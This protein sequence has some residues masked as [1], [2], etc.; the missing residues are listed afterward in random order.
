MG[1]QGRI[2]V[3]I[4]ATLQGTGG[5]TVEKEDGTWT[6]SPDF[7]GLTEIL[8][9]S[10]SDPSSK[11][12]WIY[13]PDE[14]EYNVLT[15]SGLGDALFVATSTTSLAIGTGSKSF[16][17]QAGK[18]FSV[19]SFVLATSDADEADYMLGQVTDYTDTSLTVNV[20]HTG[21]SGTDADWTIRG[22]SPAGATGSTGPGYAATSTTSLL[23]G[24]GSKAFTTQSGL[25]YSAG[26]RV[27]ASSA[28]NG[29][30]Y[31]E[32]LVTSYSGTTL[33]VNVTK[34]GGSGTLADWNI[35]LAGDPGSGDLLSTNNLS[36]VASA[37]TSRTNLGVGTGDSPEF[38]AVNVG[39]ASD[40]TV[41]RAAAGI[42]QVESVPL[43]S[44]VPQNS[45]SA[46]YT[47]VLADAQKHILHPSSDNNPRTFTIDSNANVAYPVGTVLVFVNQINTVT[48]AITSDTLTSTW[49]ATGSRTLAAS[50]MAVALKVGTTSWVIS[51]AGLS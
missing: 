28:A 24:T 44:Q 14:N 6:I 11:Q 49:G 19:G 13:D 3:R 21:G 20:T 30:N 18:N 32:G 27:R 46:A 4:P 29:A 45:Q 16:T 47:T 40:T 51:G 9:S 25:A 23:I 7:S 2:L 43:Y 17:T 26:A 10:V 42:I 22:S 31:M 5:I 38:T 33:T 35:N 37:T 8:A 36:D 39:H 50:G 1:L 34:V 15:L 48:I 41:S 12:I